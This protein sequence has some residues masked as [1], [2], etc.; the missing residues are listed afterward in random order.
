[1]QMQKIIL[2]D[3]DENI[4]TSVAMALEAEDFAVGAFSDSQKGLDEILETH[5][6]LVVLDVKMPGLDG[7]AVLER[8]R[9]ASD[10]P[11]I[12]LTSKDDEVDEVLGLRLGA[13]DYITKPFSQRLL[14]ERIR[15]ILR[16]EAARNMPKDE[17]QSNTAHDSAANPL[18]LDK[19]RHLCEWRGQ[20]INLTVTEF[21][22]IEALS[23]R[24][25]QVL[26]RDQLI[27]NAYGANIYVDDRTI[28]AHI[29]RVRKKFKIADS[30]FDEIET[31]Y[32]IGYR[33]KDPKAH[34]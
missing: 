17:T 4:L 24:L 1:M 21:M 34:A 15:T 27:D 12:F 32:G 7:F 25:G 33:F 23:A 11:V 10:V 6:D 30:E 20:V 9:K 3:D 28:D 22:L 16:R 19:A 8:L 13:D 18:L 5:P 31:L 26:S 29:R 2:V 14:I